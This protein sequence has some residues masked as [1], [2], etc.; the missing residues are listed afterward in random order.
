M[1]YIVVPH[2]CHRKT[3]VNSVVHKIQVGLWKMV[4]GNQRLELDRQYV[5]I[6]NI[7]CVYNYI[8][9]LYQWSFVRHHTIYRWYSYMW[10]WYYVYI[11]IY[12]ISQHVIINYMIYI[13]THMWIE[14]SHR[15]IQLVVCSWNHS[16]PTSAQMA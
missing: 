9:N 1:A 5:Y 6:Y 11:Y 14:R 7:Y 4:S 13:Y 15:S 10:I 12:M 8:Y 2:S 3:L 16:L